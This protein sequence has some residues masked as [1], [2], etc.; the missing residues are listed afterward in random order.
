MWAWA[1]NLAHF[2][3]KWK[4]APLKTPGFQQ[5]QLRVYPANEKC[6]SYSDIPHLCP[7][8]CP[9][10]RAHCYCTTLRKLAQF[11][12]LS[13]VVHE[14]TCE[15]SRS[16]LP[17]ANRKLSHIFHSQ[18]PSPIERGDGSHTYVAKH[19]QSASALKAEEKKWHHSLTLPSLAMVSV[20]PMGKHWLWWIAVGYR[21][22]LKV[23][24]NFTLQTCNFLLFA[25]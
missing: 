3:N 1:R 14:G 8:S 5:G 7:Q 10:L 9:W 22:H 13:V 2:R 25:A 20:P 11:C 19:L 17:E 15:P 21:L 16:L 23:L 12:P 18:V 6:T 4:P 24:V